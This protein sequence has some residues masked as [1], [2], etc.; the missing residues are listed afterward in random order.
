MVKEEKSTAISA[1]SE[2]ITGS[3][4]VRG[5]YKKPAA[6][7][8]IPKKITVNLDDDITDLIFQTHFYYKEATTKKDKPHFT[9]VVKLN[10]KEVERAVW[11]DP[12]VY[13]EFE[14]HEGFLQV[15]I[16]LKKYYLQGEKRLEFELHLEC[17]LEEQEWKGGEIK[18]TASA[19]DSGKIIVNLGSYTPPGPEPEISL[20]VFPT[21]SPGDDMYSYVNADWGEPYRLELSLN[22]KTDFVL[23]KSSSFELFEDR[24]KRETATLGKDLGPKQRTIVQTVKKAKTKATWEIQKDNSQEN[25]NTPDYFEWYKDVGGGKFDKKLN[26][27]IKLHKNTFAVALISMAK[28]IKSLGGSYVKRARIFRR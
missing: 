20:K 1:G 22:N 10:G 3:K 13:Y 26:N 8:Q 24:I 28:S 21:H 19:Y 25:K 16:N 4:I 7:V 17:W 14:E 9:L 12:D 23:K 27:N 15:E 2:E 5:I 6:S 11:S 18:E